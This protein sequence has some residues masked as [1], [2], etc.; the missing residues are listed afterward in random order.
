MTIATSLAGQRRWS[1]LRHRLP[2][3]VTEAGASRA[4]GGD[5][6]P[7]SLP[8]GG[9][10]GGPGGPLPRGW[11]GEPS[12]RGVQGPPPAPQGPRGGPRGAPGG[13]R[14]ARGARPGPPGGP[15]NRDF[16]GRAKIGHFVSFLAPKGGF[17]GG[18]D[19]SRLGELL[20][21]LEN[22]QNL[23]PPGGRGIPRAPG[24]PGGAPG[25]PPSRGLPWGPGGHPPWGASP[26]P[27]GREG[28]RCQGP[29]PTPPAPGLVP[30]PGTVLRQNATECWPDW[31]SDWRS[32]WME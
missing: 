10:S 25:E 16:P 18:Q 21:T 23:A 12:Q 19:L 6:V 28:P 3:L 1:S 2:V 31:R 8:P 4:Q 7:G 20:N 13:A 14:G 11:S 5:W 15:K 9:W 27:G 29:L 22:V 30:Y 26:R 32:D 24:A 17:S